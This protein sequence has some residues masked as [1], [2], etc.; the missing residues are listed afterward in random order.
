MR[1]FDWRKFYFF[2]RKLSAN[3][4]ETKGRQEKSSNTRLINFMISCNFCQKKMVQQSMDPQT[5][6]EVGVFRRAMARIK[7]ASRQQNSKEY[8]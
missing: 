3:I 7:N 5:F 1:H 4:V 6:N 2:A 8:K